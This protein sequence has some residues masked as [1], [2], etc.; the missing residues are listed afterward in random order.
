MITRSKESSFAEMEVNT[1]DRYLMMSLM[2]RESIHMQK[3]KSTKETLKMAID[4]GLAFSLRPMG[5]DMKAAGE[6]M[7]DME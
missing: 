7:R 1:M 2:E 6:N 3:E 5:Q 4:T